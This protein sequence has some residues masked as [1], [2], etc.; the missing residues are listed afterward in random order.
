MMMTL[1]SLMMKCNIE[2]YMMKLKINGVL[3]DNKL[4]PLEILPQFEKIYVLHITKSSDL[5]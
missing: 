5:F 1:Q 2:V 4:Y 3:N